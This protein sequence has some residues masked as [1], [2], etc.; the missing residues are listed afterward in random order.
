MGAFVGSGYK[1]LIEIDDWSIQRSIYHTNDTVGIC[2][3]KCNSSWMRYTV[4]DNAKCMDCDTKIPQDVLGLWI[5][6]NFDKYAD[7]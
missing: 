1:L 7:I 6:Y 2:H 5:L 4:K 3:S